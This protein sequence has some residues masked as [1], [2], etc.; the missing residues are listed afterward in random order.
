MQIS[1]FLSFVKF[2]L[3]Q[4]ANLH[5][6]HGL[7]RPGSPWARDLQPRLL[8]QRGQRASQP[9]QGIYT[10][11]INAFDMLLEE[12]CAKGDLEDPKSSAR[13]KLLPA[14]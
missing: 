3:Q 10:P 7:R 5:F 12:R 13:N 8:Q 2:N 14:R 9:G 4:S 11:G 6:A 1:V